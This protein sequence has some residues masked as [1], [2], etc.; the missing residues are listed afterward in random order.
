MK[1]R[2]RLLIG[3]A[4][5]ALTALLSF[6]ASAGPVVVGSVHPDTQKI[7]IFED[8]LVKKFLDG[9][10]IT[11]IYG[12]FEPRTREFVMIRSG[13][14]GAGGCQTD[15]F[16][17]LRVSGNRLVIADRQL[18]R[19][20]WDGIG[21]VPTLRRCLSVQCSGMCEALGDPN[22]PEDLEDFFCLCSSNSGPCV[23]VGDLAHRS[24]DIV[25]QG[26]DGGDPGGGR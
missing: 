9:T 16:R 7:T 12:R 20:A 18:P 23:A 2:L 24:E 21:T 1:E 19:V 11:T 4:T 5:L 13:R 26:P 15:A 17:L 10:P 3:G 6:E 22:T 25:W 14:T 8:L